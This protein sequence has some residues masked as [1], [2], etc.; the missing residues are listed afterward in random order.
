ME[1]LP[2]RSSLDAAGEFFSVGAPLHAV[3]AG[4][5]RRAADEV[6]YET[7]V[8]GRYAHVIAPYRTGKSSLIAATAARL[9]NNGFKVAILD[10]EQISD[11]DAGSD[12][13]RWYYSV[14]YRLVRQLRIRMDLQSWWQDKSILSSRQ[15][16][17]EF[18]SEVVLQNVQDR[19]A[20]FVDEVQSVGELPFDDQFLPSIRSAHNARATDPEFSRLTFVL[21]GECDPLSLIAES[22]LS[23][24]N[25]TQAVT[26]KDFSREELGIFATELNLPAEEA[27]AALDRIYY[28]TAGQPYL[29]QKLARAVS[30]EQPRDDIA[31]HVD[32]IVANQLTGRSALHNEPHLSHIHRAVVNDEKLRDGLLNLFGRLGKGINVQ[33]DLGSQLQR[34]LIAIGLLVIDADG[35]LVLRNRVYEAVFTTRWANENLPTHWRTLA[36][37]AAAVV[38]ILAVP[39]WYTQLLPRG[40]VEVLTSDAASL[41]VAAETYRNFRSFPGHRDSA[42]NLYRVF[43]QNRARG[44]TTSEDV[45]AIAD[46][47]ADLP[48]AGFLPDEMRAAFRDR[49]AIAAMREERRDDALLASLD[50]LLLST[51]QRRRRAAALVDDDYPHLLATL[52]K[53][54]RNNVV[55]NPGSLLLTETRDAQVSQWSLGTQG[56]ERRSDWMLTALEVAPLV[57]R[58]IVDR[59]GR[60]NR[61][62][63]TLNLSHARVSDLRIKVIAPSGRAVEVY[64]PAD[65]AFS[66]MDIQIPP[67][68]MAD[69]VGEPLNGTWSLSVRDEELGVAGRLVGW[70]LKLNSQG[71]IEDFQRGL[72]I[73]DPIERNTDHVWFSADGRYAVARAMQ[74]DSA[75]LW[76]LAFAKPVRAIAVSEFE[77]VVGLGAGARM[78]VTATQSTASLW[79]TATG[80]RVAA[81]PVGPA[82]T[83]AT[84]NDAGTHLFVQR[85][86]DVDTR[87]ELWSLADAAIESELTV[88]GTPALVALDSRGRRIA[89]AD[90]DRA[91]R[92]WDF[93]SGELV[94]QIGLSAQPSEIRMAATGDVLG[95]VFGNEGAS[96]WRVDRP[97]APIVRRTGPGRWQL[98][99][100]PS[101][102][103]A[104]LGRDGYGFQTY[105]TSDGLWLGPPLG[106]GADYR[107]SGLLGFSADEQVIVTGGPASIA[108]FWRAPAAPAREAMPPAAAL[109]DLW[110]ASGNAVAEVTSDATTVVIG[111]NQGDVHFVPVGSNAEELLEQAQRVSF[112]GHSSPVRLVAVSRN[113]ARA[114]SVAADNSI[115][116][117]DPATGLPEPFFAGIHGNPVEALALAPDGSRA[118]FM[119][120]NRV[121]VMEAGDGRMVARFELG[122]RSRAMSFADD[123]SLY[124]GNESGALQ[125]V[126]Q[127]AGGAWT[128]RTIWQGDAPL[129]GLAVS[130]RSSYL[131]VVDA[132][133]RA[134]QFSLAEG[135]LG[136]MVLDLPS[137]IEEVSFAPGG[138][139]VLFRT[140][141]WVHR[142]SSA[143]TGLVWIDAALAPQGLSGAPMVFG[144]AGDG[145]AALANRVYLPVPGAGFARLAQVS[146][147]DLSGPGLFGNRETLL[148]E[149]WRRLGR[150]PGAAN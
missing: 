30:R 93:G 56:L 100:S 95:V 75:R 117:W 132:A 146:F 25:V 32:R 62:G 66:N 107:N 41:A 144:A 27:T 46:M 135:R 142:A 73:A 18:Y 98:A 29:S 120:S 87:F 74:S 37:S 50:S 140:Q 80:K 122:V 112:L 63:L 44:A 43:L 2:E 110:P 116:V 33:T 48:D 149:W 76:D 47:A 16:L 139:R 23:P 115:R 147:G 61:A 126:A 127:D 12:E 111:D 97:G 38:A 8:A 19:V 148:D 137:T 64:P 20:I 1:P 145:A 96:L 53:G 89:V 60:V 51:P 15:R 7:V 65:A 52:A 10:L 21:A 150:E 121:Y 99:F 57:R 77:K 28:W 81:L 119:S 31:A 9:E 129:R 68:Q 67:A 4:Y 105:A 26:L 59:D 138:T 102:T 104:L 42:D 101:G 35:R 84:L 55:F 72:N 22:E 92:I 91:V 128:I 34:R 11:R 109:Q 133:N 14:A 13:G 134:M 118:A 123:G 88:A 94:A 130:P 40:Y 70:N 106:M 113:D 49:Q 131:V 78:L 85:H 24:F 125:V 82:S 71:V 45:A 83:S 6:L 79:D 5:V 58:V 103:R 108:R 90:Y 69:L 86:S 36:W 39:F 54:D 136:E 141:R 17:L 114:V 3:R 143:R 124:L